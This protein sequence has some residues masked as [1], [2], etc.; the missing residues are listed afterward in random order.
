MPGTPEVTPGV[1]HG[2]G[3]ALVGEL[4]GLNSAQYYDVMEY[5]AH[6]QRLISTHTALL[7]AL[8]ETE[9]PAIVRAYLSGLLEGVINAA[10]VD[11]VPGKH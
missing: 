5:E 8:L 6:Q 1:A 3:M 7:N 11:F 4:L 2:G 10:S 9:D